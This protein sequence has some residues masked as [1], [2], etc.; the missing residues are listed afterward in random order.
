MAKRS[1]SIWFHILFRP[2][3][4]GGLISVTRKNGFTIALDID[5]P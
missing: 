2:A 3:P 5:R 4:A 1:R